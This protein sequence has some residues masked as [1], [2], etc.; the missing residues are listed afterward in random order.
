MDQLIK[1]LPTL[2]KAAGDA[3]EVR[4]A[5]AKAAWNRIAGEAL[6]WHAV[7]S[8]LRGQTLVVAIADVIWQKQLEAMAAQLLFRLNTL[9]GQPLVTYLEFT[10]DP[11]AIASAS[12][13]KQSTRPA[14]SAVQEAPFELRLAA[15]AIHDPELR[16]VF[17]R[18]AGGAVRR[19][20]GGE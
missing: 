5:A 3:E 11:K 17:L 4:E 15:G 10:V 19:L 14:Q 13:I 1:A 16:R 8:L 6:R 9:V 7:P 18:A 2:L 12:P 20:E